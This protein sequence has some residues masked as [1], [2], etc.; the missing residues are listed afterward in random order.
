MGLDLY[1]AGAA[2]EDGCVF[3]AAWRI[4]GLDTHVLLCGGKFGGRV[5]KAILSEGPVSDQA[6]VETH[7]GFLVVDEG[8]GF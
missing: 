5:I 4:D 6:V 1:E 2:V 7:D 8:G 3:G